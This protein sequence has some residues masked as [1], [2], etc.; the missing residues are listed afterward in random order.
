MA[1]RIGREGSLHQELRRGVTPAITQGAFDFDD[2]HLR[3]LVKLGLG[4]RADARDLFDY[5][6][7]LRYTEIQTDLLP[8]LLPFC[9]EAW[10]EDLRGS[11]AEYG[12]F[13]EQFY[14]VLADRQ[15]FDKH[16]SPK[17]TGAVS[18]FMRQ[19]ILDEI[20][21]QRG[22]V[23]HGSTARPYRWIRA[24]ATYGVLLPDI[25]QIWVA[26]WSLSTIGQAVA[27]LQYT[28]CLMFP[29]N[30]NPVFPAWTRDSGGGPP[31][32]WGFDGLCTHRWLQQNIEFLKRT[33]STETVT[34]A[35]NRAEECLLG[36]PEHEVAVRM[37]DDFP[38]HQATVEARCSEL[39]R[40]L[41]TKDAPL[42]WL[43]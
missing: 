36:E 21:D 38:V 4:D 40:L 15:V 5:T 42:N 30:K 11:T 24:F 43:I 17:Q 26:W 9:L 2:R 6:Q 35:L 23:F 18:E 34:R 27:L 37:K 25:D 20:D 31:C 29:E 32:L 12:G 7:D 1:T 28:S 14:P 39:P 10:R 19:S 13:V 3:R 33:L 41:Q 16:L 22:L 8:H